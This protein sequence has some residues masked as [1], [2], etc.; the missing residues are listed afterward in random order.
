MDKK[1]INNHTLH[2]VKFTLPKT[3]STIHS[4]NLFIFN[5]LQCHKTMMY[6][7]LQNFFNFIV[8]LMKMNGF[9]TPIYTCVSILHHHYYNTYIIYNTYVILC[10]CVIYLL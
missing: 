9:N 10:N 2:L 1:N 8:G 7:C 5:T 4:C 6:D 3:T